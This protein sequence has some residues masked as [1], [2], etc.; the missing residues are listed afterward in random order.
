MAEEEPLTPVKS[1]PPIRVTTCPAMETESVGS[2]C[3]MPLL[4]VWPM[5]VGRAQGADKNSIVDHA[6]IMFCQ[7]L[8]NGWALLGPFGEDSQKS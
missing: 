2:I 8:D 5:M 6:G 1:S 3:R 7:G 4:E